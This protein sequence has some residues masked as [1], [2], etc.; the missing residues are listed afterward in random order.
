MSLL[1]FGGEGTEPGYLTDPRHV[2]LDGEGNI[3]VGEWTGKRIHK[4]DA[5]GNFISVWNTKEDLAI[6]GMAVN[7]QGMVYILQGY[8]IFLYE[9]A[10]G[11]FKG[12]LYYKNNVSRNAIPEAIGLDPEGRLIVFL[13]SGTKHY[14]LKFDAENK[15]SQVFDISKQTESSFSGFLNLAT[16]SL[17]TVYVSSPHDDAIYTFSP[18]GKLIDKFGSKGAEAGQFYS[19]PGSLA[20][21]AQDRIFVADWNNIR[22]FES[23]GRFVDVFET[24]EFGIAQGVAFGPANEFFAVFHTRAQV[25][26]FVVNE[27]G[28]P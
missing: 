5:S 13:S 7:L 14:L 6:A 9:G 23:D 10:S 24:K 21:D 2:A 8:R 1:F 20:F 27:N 26:K 12:E 4:F 28:Q 22:I 11:E 17:G 3:Y 15:E 16:D 19:G 25:V 18:D